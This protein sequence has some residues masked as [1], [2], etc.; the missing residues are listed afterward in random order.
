MLTEHQIEQFYKDG[1]LL[2]PSVWT[3]EQI[4][5]LRHTLINLFASEIQF[6][7]DTP[8]LRIDIFARYKQLHWLIVH[9]PLV[10]ALKSLLGNDFVYLPEMAAHKSFY[11]SWHKD[12]TSQEA[13]G[14]IFQWQPN[15]LMVEAAI[16][17][18]DN[19]EYGGGLDVIPG[20][21][22]YP[23]LRTNPAAPEFWQK[24]TPTP[25]TYSVPSKAGDLVLFD[26]RI[27]HKATL[28]TNSSIEEIPEEKRKLAIFLACSANNEH[29]VNY[30]QF[31]SSRS[32]Y[33]YLKDHQYPDDLLALVK[34]HNLLLI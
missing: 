4:V 16:Y 7:G 24:I 6:K 34:H 22:L 32:D 25:S 26:F 5:E 2:I 19:D 18:Q 13:A 11:S 9:P 15:Y 28:P 3:K 20:S 10:A 31:I 21:H 12:T 17:L 33:H 1:F 14:N 30:K 8:Q 29:V 27:D 23:D